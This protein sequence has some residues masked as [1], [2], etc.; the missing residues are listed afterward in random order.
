MKKNLFAMA[1]L[2]VSC[3][4]VNAQG[5][6]PVVMTINGQPVT[7]SEFEYFYHKNNDQDVVEQKSFDEYVELFVNYKL[8]VQEALSRGIDTTQAYKDELAGYRKQLAEPYLLNESWKEKA[9]QEVLKN[10]QEEVHGAHILVRLDENASPKKVSEAYAK[11]DSIKMELQNGASFDSL[12]RVKS[13]DPSAA[14]NGG[15]LGYF[16]V[17]Q[18][19][20]PFE[21]AAYETPVGEVAVLRSQFGVHLL[22]V[23]DRRAA[24]PEV[25]VA[26]IMKMF[27]RTM[28]P[29]LA[30]AQTKPYIDSVYQVLQ[31]GMPFAEVA[32]SASEDQYTAQNGGAYPWLN[33]AAQ[34][35]EEW[36]SVAYALKKNEISAPFKTNF[37]WHI[38]KKLDERSPAVAD[39]AMQEE[40]R[41]MLTRDPARSASFRRQQ[42]DQWMLEENMKVNEKALSA[43]KTNKVFITLGKQKYTVQDFNDWCQAQYGD[44]ASFVPQKEAIDAYKRVLITAYE[45]EHLADKYADFRNLYKEYHD[46][47][48]LFDV[49]GGE[50]WDKAAKDSIGL[51]KYF[52]NHRAQYTW[53]QPHFKGAFIEC[54]DDEML[55]AALKQIY[56]HNADI[57]ACA[58]E[59]RAK[60]L[61]DSIL[62]PN[63]KIPRFHIVNGLY[64]P[65][66]NNTVDRERLH[67]QVQPNEPRPNMPVRMTYGRVIAAPESFEDVRTAV[68]TDYQNE[69]EQKWVAELRA[70][71]PVVLNQKEL[72]K[73]R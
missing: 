59:V 45:D 37:G 69:L 31:G 4:S 44:E 47:I 13:E 18:M 16:G 34:F 61:T 36:M 27:P 29:Q 25:L 14:R 46:G 55:I 43:K 67:L 72:D 28:P 41:E 8:K 3:L 49:A 19:V 22:K 53:S 52:E 38:M 42:E 20:Y 54:A 35:P 23:I 7:R 6:D 58:E 30:A 63:P 51:Q 17:M 26:H 64:A 73:L 21:K 66:D 65:G 15:D 2:A 24:R 56:D 5:D 33:S 39:S 1:M 70:K 57:Q 32:A 9:L 62:T 48:L 68:I 71:F 12:A 10:R 50:V 40:M 11:I 60:V